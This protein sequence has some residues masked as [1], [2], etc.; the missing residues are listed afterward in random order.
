MEIKYIDYQSTDDFLTAVA[1]KCVSELTEK[2][3]QILLEETNLMVF[4]FG[5]GMY[6]R[7]KFIYPQK[8]FESDDNCAKIFDLLMYADHYSNTVVKL[9]IDL[10]KK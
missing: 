3:K 7:N 5:I 1:K 9:I 8:K 10:L 4:H 6:I 2:D